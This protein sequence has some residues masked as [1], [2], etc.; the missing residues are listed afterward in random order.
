VSRLG[1]LQHDACG[2]PL[3]R[4]AASRVLCA[5]RLFVTLAAAR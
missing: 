1:G 2:V 4:A 3:H 5:C